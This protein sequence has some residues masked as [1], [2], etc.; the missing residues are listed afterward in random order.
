MI[1]SDYSEKFLNYLTKRNVSVWRIETKKQGILFNIAIDDY[2]K[3]RKFRK[4]S[5][6]RIKIKLISKFGFPLRV[7]RI[8]KRP[9]LC[10]G[11]LL[12]VLINLFLS[13]FIWQIEVKGNIDNDEVLDVCDSVGI[14]IGM[15]S[16]KIDTY[17]QPQQIALKLD[18]AAWISL[19]IEG[20]KLTVNVSK[21]N[22]HD[23]Q[24]NKPC[25]IVASEDAVIRSSKVRVGSNLTTIGKAVRKGDLL[26]SGVVENTEKTHFVCSDADILGETHRSYFVEVDK[27]LVLNEWSYSYEQRNILTFFGAQIPLYLTDTG[28]GFIPIGNYEKFITI[29]NKVIP[30]GVRGRYYCEKLEN[31]KSIDKELA[32]NI[33]LGKVCEELGDLPVE[34]VKGYNVKINETNR[35]FKVYIDVT[36]LE[37]ICSYREIVLDD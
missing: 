34:V 32:K 30:I 5:G 10:A 17:N 11:L 2:Y 15:Y 7:R 4:D 6:L 19:N 8:F 25:N 22:T 29:K 20:S 24:V 18:N 12:F 27:E 31:K 16:G 1:I 14:K 21:A 35:S 3:I 33:A 36:S 26:V 37:N 9:G 23:E 13:S 28:K